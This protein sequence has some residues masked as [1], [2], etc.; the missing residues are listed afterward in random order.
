MGWEKKKLDVKA[1]VDSTI[2][3]S[4]HLPRQQRKTS[5]LTIDPFLIVILSYKLQQQ[6][7]SQ[8]KISTDLKSFLQDFLCFGTTDSAMDSNLFISADTEGSYSVTG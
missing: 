5:C 1:H 7:S 2:T 6:K 4:C 8:V 3:I